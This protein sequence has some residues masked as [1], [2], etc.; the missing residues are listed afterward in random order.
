MTRALITVPKTANR[1]EII[2]IRAIVAHPMETGYRVRANGSHLPRN[3]INRFVCTYDG[4]EIFSAD[5]FPAISA[6]PFVSFTTV[7][8]VSG[9]ITFAW[10]DDEGQTQLA[11][12]DI[13]VV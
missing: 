9:T 12:A 8:T 10:T 4:A 3:I 11:T 2:E 1:G 6:N 13:T 7:A 5:F